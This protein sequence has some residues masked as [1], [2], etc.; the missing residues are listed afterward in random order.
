MTRDRGKYTI[1]HNNQTCVIN[2]S[3]NSS[4]IMIK[5][6]CTSESIKNYLQCRHYIRTQQLMQSFNKINLLT[7]KSWF[8]MLVCGD[9]IKILF[10][11][12]QITPL[13]LFM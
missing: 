1:L 11:V 13:C 8:S 9:Y 10:K 2:I 12:V 5:Y 7:P 3:N 4:A 6:F